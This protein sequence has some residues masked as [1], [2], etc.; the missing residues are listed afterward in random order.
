MITVSPFQKAFTKF[1]AGKASIACEGKEQVREFAEICKGCGLVLISKEEVDVETVVRWLDGKRYLCLCYVGGFLSATSGDTIFELDDI[2]L[3][4]LVKYD[5]TA[6]AVAEKFSSAEQDNFIK[7]LEG[8]ITFSFTS[9]DELRR[10]GEACE[11]YERGL[12]EGN[13]TPSDVAKIVRT[14]DIGLV[15]AYRD[16]SFGNKVRFAFS[17]R[18]YLSRCTA[19]NGLGNNQV[20]SFVPDEDKY[21]YEITIYSNGE[22]TAAKMRVNGETVKVAVAC[23]H[24]EDKFSWKT[25]ATLAFDRLFTKNK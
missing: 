18:E 9:P 6:L 11:R 4:W 5:F 21:K 20:V 15:Y 3:D 22:S 25:G 19:G 1:V 12:F 23:L 16:K 10:F 13:C 2:G 7:F 8:E 14:H 17:R 24:P